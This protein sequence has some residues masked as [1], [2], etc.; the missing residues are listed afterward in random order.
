MAGDGGVACNFFSAFA[1]IG[2]VFALVGRRFGVPKNWLAF[3]K[4]YPC[5]VQGKGVGYSI[6]SGSGRVGSGRV[7]ETFI[8]TFMFFTGIEILVSYYL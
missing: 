8:T 2:L 5:H 1:W 6:A 7:G 4:P 3:V